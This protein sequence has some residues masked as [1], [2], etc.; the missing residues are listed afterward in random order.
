MLKVKK[1]RLATVFLGGRREEGFTI[2]ELMIASALSLIVMAGIYT[3]YQSQTRSYVVREQITVMQQN[4]RAGMVLMTSDIRMAGYKHPKI[5][6]S[7]IPG[8]TVAET[9][10]IEFRLMNNKTDNPNSATD[11]NFDK[12]ETI[13]YSLVNNNLVKVRTLEGEAADDPLI[14]AENIDWLD[15][16]Y[17]KDD[18]TVTGTPTEIKSIEITMVARTGRGDRDYSDLAVHGAYKNQRGTTIFTPDANDNYRRRILTRQ[19]QCRNL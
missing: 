18:G 8:I 4:L 5:T 11:P 17:L 1:G 12:L 7:S 6:T 3:I 13:K 9:D 2:V 19:I 10:N 14:I 15:F 16:V